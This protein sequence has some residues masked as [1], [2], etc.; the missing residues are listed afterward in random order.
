M[1]LAWQCE[2][3]GITFATCQVDIWIEEV[4]HL[5][6]ITDDHLSPYTLQHWD[7]Q[8]DEGRTLITFALD[9][10]QENHNVDFQSDRVKGK[11]KLR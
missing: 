7:V 11:R 9:Q 6:K 4:D 8:A 2:E 1:T 3:S 5:I 10:V